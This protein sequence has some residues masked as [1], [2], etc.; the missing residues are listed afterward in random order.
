MKLS[1]L[2]WILSA[3]AIWIV[4]QVVPGF[5]VDGALAAFLAA[6]I[7][8]FI[9]GTLGFVLKLLTLPL[10]VVTFGLF[11]LVINA[12]MIQLSS[13]IIPGFHVDGFFS[14]FLG[15][16]VLSIVNMALQG[17]LGAAKED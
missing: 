3:L 17:L 4:A 13:M 7:I 11:L 15:G 5:S 12:L 8:G 6:V 14:A 1:I 16:I 2:S 9:N 10:S